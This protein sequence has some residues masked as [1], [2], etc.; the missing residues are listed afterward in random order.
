MRSRPSSTGTLQRRTSSLIS[1]RGLWRL[2]FR[3]R[4]FLLARA[5][6]DSRQRVI[7]LVAGVLVNLIGRRAQRNLTLPRL[8]VRRR[9]FDGELIQDFVRRNA[10]EAFSHLARRR[11]IEALLDA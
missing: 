1:G 4:F 2:A 7:A 9:I 6:K 10:R 5:G 3:R 11:Q 8:C